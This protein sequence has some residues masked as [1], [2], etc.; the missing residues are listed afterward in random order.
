MS[1]KNN[2]KNLSKALDLLVESEADLSTIFDDGGLIQQLTKNVVERALHAEMNN[3][4]GYEKNEHS[5]SNNARNGKSSKTLITDH[6]VL[7]IDV[8]RDRNGDFEPEL[9][10]KRAR[11]LP[12]FDN[13]VISLYAKGMSVS[14]IQIQLKELYGGAEISAALISQITDEVLEDV[15]AWQ[16]RPLDAVYPIVFF[17]C[18][19]VKVREDKR[20]IN[21]SVYIALGINLEGKKEVLGLWI[22]QNEGAKFWL[23]NLTE[24]KNRGV[25]D[26]LIACTDNLT[27]MN[28][29]IASAFPQTE[30]QLCIVHQIRNSLKYVPYK[31]RKAVAEDLKKIYQS[32]T[33]SEAKQA[34]LAFSEKWDSS[35]PHISKSWSAHWDNL[36]IF[37]QYPEEI[38]KVIYTTNAIE[39]LNSQLRKVTKNKKVFPSNEAVFKSLYLAIEYIS[40][41]WSMPIRN[42]GNAMAHFLIVFEGRI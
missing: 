36:M 5:E 34:L 16:N 8:P 23:G 40:Q 37:L 28:E 17:D 19:V 14:D 7:E 29:A 32:S 18:L 22:S 25:R 3:H 9:V 11:R 30:H 27:G 15:M 21:K 2:N 4:L 39:S 38:R 26:I 31:K 12:G 6:G 41:K 10:P 20:V 35:Y 1:M 24:M 33:E 13:K 42:W